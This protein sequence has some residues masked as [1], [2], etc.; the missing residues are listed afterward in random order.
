MNSVTST[1]KIII[2]IIHASKTNSSSSHEIWSLGK[3]S[4]S[5]H[6]RTEYRLCEVAATQV[7]VCQCKQRVSLNPFQSSAAPFQQHNIQTHSQWDQLWHARIEK[8]VLADALGPSH[9]TR[10]LKTDPR[11]LKRSR[12]EKFQL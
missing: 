7:S 11:G 3:I 6:A 5:Q 1:L 12:W 9:D 4:Q 10:T 2:I 8:C